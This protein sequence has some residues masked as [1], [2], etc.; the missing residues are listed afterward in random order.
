MTGAWGP[1]ERGA[2]GLQRRQEAEASGLGE[3]RA[4]GQSRAGCQREA[5]HPQWSREL[6]ARAPAV[7]GIGHERPLSSLP[8]S[9]PAVSGCSGLG[10]R[11][12]PA[13]IKTS[14]E[15]YRTWD[16][17][18]CQGSAQWQ[19]WKRGQQKRSAEGSSK[20]QGS[21]D[22]RSERTWPGWGWIGTHARAM[23]RLLVSA[24]ELRA[25]APTGACIILGFMIYF[26]W[27]F[28][29]CEPCPALWP[30]PIGSGQ[31]QAGP[32][33]TSSCWICPMRCRARVCA[34]QRPGSARPVQGSLRPAGAAAQRRASGTWR[35]AGLVPGALCLPLRGGAIGPQAS[36]S[37]QR[38]A[39]TRVG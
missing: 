29:V 14:P 23:G 6:G 10:L 22:N 18:H 35:A 34:S 3:P 28:A 2:V 5:D 20:G 38:A 1:Q 7:G 37:E 30:E 4:A 27:S 36:F 11:E 26:L 24:A 31:A 32:A 8:P 39:S 19:S 33:G 9:W 13:V 16:Q 12:G 15:E 25:K 21:H 17:R